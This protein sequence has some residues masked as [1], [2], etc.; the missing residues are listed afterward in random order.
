LTTDFWFTLVKLRTGV[1]IN[2]DEYVPIITPKIKANEN[3]FRTSPP[4]KKIAIK[5]KRVVIDVINVLE[6]VAFIEISDI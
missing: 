2:I 3:P 6:R 5:A 1:A 4:N